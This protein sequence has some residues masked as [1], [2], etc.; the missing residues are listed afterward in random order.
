MNP[1]AFWDRIAPKYARQPIRD[2][3]SYEYT[4]GRTRSYLGSGDRVLELGCGT[5]STAIRLAD[6]VARYT[7]T[8][9][10]AGMIAEARIKQTPDN[11]EL[12]TAG[13]S[14]PRLL[15]REYDAVLALNL[16][17]LLRDMP[18]VLRRVHSLLEPGGLFISKTTVAPA[19]P[20]LWF[21]LLRIGLPLLHLTGRVPFVAFR[22]IGEHDAMITAAGFQIVET[23][24][25]SGAVPSRYVV[26]RKT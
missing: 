17:H 20:P 26:A 6:G 21:P 25:G 9:V 11:L 14:E 23:F 2:M 3:K 13:W 8:D 22:T 10:S 4:L 1:T 15:D 7:A 12:L 24:D 16:L 19:R 18:S 5:G